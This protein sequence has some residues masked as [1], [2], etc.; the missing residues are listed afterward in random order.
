MNTDRK[1]FFTSKQGTYQD[2]TT[3]Y[4]IQIT[5]ENERILDAELPLLIDKG[6]IANNND[7]LAANTSG[8]AAGSH[9]DI[10]PSISAGRAK[11]E[12]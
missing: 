10:G 1:G 12:S 9:G 4:Q 5:Q 3:L 7:G 8:V 11:G 2:P 6:Y